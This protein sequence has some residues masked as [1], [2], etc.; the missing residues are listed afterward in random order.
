MRGDAPLTRTARGPILCARPC[1]AVPPAPDAVLPTSDP[2]EAFAL[3]PYRLIIGL[4][5]V[6]I[7]LFWAV[8]RANGLVYDDP[9][10]YR[11][12]VS[13]LGFAVLASTY[14]GER[15]RRAAFAAMVGLVYVIVALVTWIGV[16]N[17]LP[18]NLMAGVGLAYVVCGLVLVL[19]AASER[20]VVARLVALVAVALGTAAASVGP[21]GI[22]LPAS[23]FAGVTGMI[24][25]VVALSGV[26]R[27]RALAALRQSEARVRSVLDAAPD[28]ILLIDAA[29]VVLDANPAVERIFGF[30]P[31]ALLGRRLVDRLVP[32]A[33][34]DAHLAA[35]RRY[36]E[37]GDGR[38]IRR[39]VVRSA[40]CADGTA[41]PVE[42]TMRPLA[43]ASGQVLFTVH[44][45]DL[46]AQT[47]AEA[48]L[49][50]AKEAAEATARLLRTVIDAV[51]D[52]IFAVDRDGRFLVGNVAGV[53]DTSA[54]TPADLVGRTAH[55]VFAPETADAIH[56]GR[57]PVLASGRAIVDRTHPFVRADGRRRVGTTTRLPLLGP[58]GDVVGVV[59][60]TRDVTES[61][62]ADAE[63]RA[64]RATLRSILDTL[65]DAVVTVDARDIVLDA[66]PAVARVLGMTPEALVG[67]RF[68]D[69]AVPPRY[70]DEHRAKLTRYAEHGH[71][72]SLGARLH[73]FVTQPDGVP[74]PVHLT[75]LPVPSADGEPVFVIHLSDLR[76]GEAAARALM[77]AREEALLA[78]DA[79]EAATRAKSEFLAN[80]SHEIRT[81]MNG[82]IGM[83]SLLLET[84]L[85]AE[86]REFVE[87]VRT[88]GDALLT[89]INDILDFSKIEAGMLSLENEPL[90]VRRAAES[91]LD[92]VAQDAAGK[93]VALS[94]AVDAGVPAAVRGDA[95][96]LRQVLVNLLSNAVKFTS[97]GR[98][99]VRISAAAGTGGAPPTVTFA[100]E[101]S[102]IGIAPDALAGIFE[103]FA[104]ADASTTRRFGGTGLGLTIS[105]RLA[106]MM[107]GTLTAESRVGVG[108]VFRLAVAAEAV[109]AD[110]APAAVPARG[111]AEAW[112]ARPAA[113]VPA[114]P[115]RVL[116]AEDNV[117]N[118]KVAVRLLARLGLRADV[119][120]NGAEA[121][122]SV[123][124]QPYDVV[125]MDVQMPEMDGLAAVRALRAD[126]G[127]FPPPAIVMLTA[128]AMEGDR[129][130]C[131]AAG[132]DDYLAK[133]VGL[134]AVAAA[135]A[136]AARSRDAA[137]V[138]A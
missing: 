138:P 127:R 90:D 18:S 84:G 46:R 69:V 2:E 61:V 34:A 15:A 22:A 58:G 23:T 54:E 17:G 133:P 5:S 70:R 94:C 49:V 119:V 52:A 26:Y 124:R 81:P 77:E 74:V 36:V 59:G 30:A 57:L 92:L 83:T 42:M 39:R 53:A 96:R 48:A 100:V 8:D 120:A 80:M 64:S 122:A 9:L 129:E 137:C 132:A 135:L 123:R 67:T 41:V 99:C 128:N 87:V 106:E 115:V 112:V 56:L 107:G 79:A 89:I 29:D 45:R 31:G 13:A 60:V 101:D 47:A 85:D 62:R 55:E 108:S 105:R 71:V 33:R 10:A 136:R 118:Q 20:V 4:G 78:R 24:G 63:L 114:A 72:G 44:L 35:L 43:Q 110:V 95:T 50:A 126:P 91:A 38:G 116:V 97:A 130:T 7:P 121:V 75:V 73:L 12:V 134:D 6:A 1:R 88:S 3:R 76:D 21:A 27:V 98:V 14:A 11:L 40:L 109:P 37:T 16:R 104:Q 117:V 32:A 131:L 65:P 68:S 111:P 19:Y 28:A 82:V 103:P 51:P 113:A 93:G 102:G 66:N 125:F 86:Q 25:A